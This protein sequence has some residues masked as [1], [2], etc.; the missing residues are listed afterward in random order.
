MDL[1]NAA[2]SLKYP[3]DAMRHIGLIPEDNPLVVS[4]IEV[5][6]VKVAKVKDQGVLIRLEPDTRTA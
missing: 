4:A 3:M 6:Q 5:K 1:D 2:A